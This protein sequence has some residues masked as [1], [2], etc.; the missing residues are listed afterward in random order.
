LPALKNLLIIVTH[1]HV[2][3][4]LENSFL[5]ICKGQNER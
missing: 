1:R 5:I 2:T 3:I 4:G